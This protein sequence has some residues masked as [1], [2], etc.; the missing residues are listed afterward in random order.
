[1]S[2][3]IERL[4]SSVVITRQAE[5]ER[6]K[7]LA[8]LQ[9]TGQLSKQ[10]KAVLW[11][12]T[13]AYGLDPALREVVVLGGNAYVTIGGLLRIAER[14]GEFGGNTYEELAPREDGEYR[15]RAVVHRRVG[16]EWRAFEG[17]GRANPRNVGMKTT[18]EM[19]LDELA[20]KRALARAIR[21]ACSIG[22]PADEEREDFGSTARPM[23]LDMG[24]LESEPEEKPAKK[25]KAHVEEEPEPPYEREP[26]DE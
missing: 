14:S 18:R 7:A 9:W 26:G 3:A 21:T 24:E 10:E 8:N 22:I 2:K 5:G 4:K 13:K 16:G 1:M 15:Y 19:W 12:L 23:P 17:L 25:G 6:E 20:Q 11:H